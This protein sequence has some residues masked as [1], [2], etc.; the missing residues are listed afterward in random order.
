M[1]SV[2]NNHTRDRRWFDGFYHYVIHRTGVVGEM[3][4]LRWSHGS[5]L[6]SCVVAFQGDYQSAEEDGSESHDTLTFAQKAAA[7]EL[8]EWLWNQPGIINAES[9]AARRRRG[10]RE[11]PGASSACPGDQVIDFLHDDEWW[12]PKPR[13]ILDRGYPQPWGTGAAGSDIVDSIA[14]PDGKGAYLLT[15]SGHIHAIPSRHKGGPQHH[16]A[17]GGMD[18]WTDDPDR[19]A[20]Q[21]RPARPDE[22]G[23]VYVV[24]SEAGEPYHYPIDER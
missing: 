15:E 7:V 19:V 16:G 6:D 1:R 21:L 9:A 11:R 14:D 5:Q 12:E 20:A 2:Q 13:Q 8:A 18:Y 3:R 10:H 24:L 23:K 4:D 17:P 22:P